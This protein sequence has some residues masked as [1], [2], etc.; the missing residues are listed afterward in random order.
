MHY[1]RDQAQRAEARAGRAEVEAGERIDAPGR[2]GSGKVRITQ[3]E[4][5]DGSGAATTTF[6]SG[7]PLTVRLH[8]VAARR[9]EKPVFGLAV[10]HESGTHV[11]G[12]NTHFGGLDIPAVEGAGVI[13]YQAPRLPLLAGLY[14][15][16]VA[17]VDG[18][19][20]ETFDYHDRL[21]D[22]Q[23]FPDSRNERYGLVTL[24]GGWQ[25]ET[26]P[27]SHAHDQRNGE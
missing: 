4:L 16:S 3:V 8:Y 6:A 5:C 18:V 21:Y 22:F 25:L 14:R 17:V 23:V 13:S 20:N 7:E 11:T 19:D 15:L 24:G 12:P 10:Y 26:R 9:V 2:W 1:L 27:K